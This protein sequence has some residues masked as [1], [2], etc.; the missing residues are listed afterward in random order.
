MNHFLTITVA[1]QTGSGK[2]LIQ[3]VIAHALWA[4]GISVDIDWGIDGDPHRELGRTEEILANVA[5]NM[6]VKV[7]TQQWPRQREIKLV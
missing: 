6:H 2:T 4:R 1:G 5:P 3:Q 7:T